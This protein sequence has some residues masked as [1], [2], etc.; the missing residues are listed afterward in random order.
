MTSA[1]ASL[2]ATYTDSEGEDDEKENN[3]EESS[4]DSKSP[5]D[6]NSD[7]KSVVSSRSES[8]ASNPSVT[9]TTR[10]AKLVSYIDDTIASD[11]EGEVDD[12]IPQQ[13][14]F[15]NENEKSQDTTNNVDDKDHLIPPEPP[16]NCS[17]DLQEKISKLYEKNA[18]SA[19]GYECC[20]TEKKRF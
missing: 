10:F 11:D 16:G 4:Q 7:N 6:S 17:A 3:V 1:L 8:P 14:I 12:G 13:I 19:N 2:T 18:N 15:M 9:V 20:H 5:H